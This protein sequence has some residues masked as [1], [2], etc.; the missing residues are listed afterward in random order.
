MGGELADLGRWTRSGAYER[1]VRCGTSEIPHKARGQCLKCVDRVR[2]RQPGRRTWAR[3]WRARNP[4][5]VREAQARDY[6]LHHE[7]R[8]DAK[9]REYATLTDGERRGRIARNNVRKKKHR[10][11]VQ[12]FVDAAMAGG[13]VDC[14]TKEQVVLDLDHVRGEKLGG[15]AAL[16]DAPL[17]LVLSEI[18]KCETRCSNCHRRVTAARRKAA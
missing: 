5:R 8:L 7:R 9:A 16:K 18:D 14:G 2:S 15:L 1:C 4:S 13:C 11:L 17:P 3:E 6:A 12:A 10:A